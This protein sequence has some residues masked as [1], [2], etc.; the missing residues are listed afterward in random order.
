MTEENK[1][2][3]IG[4][5]VA[6]AENRLAMA[7]LVFQGSGQKTATTLAYYGAFHYA[8]ALILMEGLES[9]THSG[10]F[11]LLNLHFVRSGR[12]S[13]ELAKVL[14]DLQNDREAAEYDVASVFTP[15]MAREAITDARR[16]ADTA[17]EILRTA[18]YL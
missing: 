16:F 4:Q 18:G 3:N 14:R 5:E 2:H 7:E 10:V 17:R 12:L 6:E 1:K 8:R 9:K 13:P 15:D 11:S